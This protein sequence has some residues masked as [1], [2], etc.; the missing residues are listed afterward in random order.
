M[1]KMWTLIESY[2]KAIGIGLH[3]DF[4]NLIINDETIQYLDYDALN[5]KHIMFKE[6]LICICF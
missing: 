3:Y 1:I 4:N 6:Y 2:F 5:Y